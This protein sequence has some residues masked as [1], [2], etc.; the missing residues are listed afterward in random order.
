MTL[1]QLKIGFIP[2]TDAA[3]LVM[4]KE[5]GFFEEEGLSVDLV[6]AR[7]WAQTRDYLAT[8]ELDAAHMLAPMVPASWLPG[9]TG[10]IPFV[11]GLSLNLNGNAITV[12]SALY[13]EMVEADPEALTERPLSSRALKSVLAKRLETTGEPVTFGTVFPFSSHNYAL[14][15]WLADEYIDPDRDV[16][17]VVAPPQ[18]MVEQ[19]EKGLI[20][21]FCVG[22]PWNSLAEARGAGRVILRSREIWQDMPEKVLGVRE[23]W[24]KEHP[25]THLKL[26]KAVLRACQWLDTPKHRDEAAYHLAGP[27]YL[28][29]NPGVLSVALSSKSVKTNYRSLMQ[30][31]DSIIFHHNAANFPWQSHACWFL[32]QMI[33]WGQVTEDLDINQIAE[34]CYLPDLYRQAAHDLG[35]LA[36]ADASKVEGGQDR[37]WILPAEGGLIP[38]S[39]NRFF[40]QSAFDP[41]RIGSYINSFI[42]HNIRIDTSKI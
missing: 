15:Y 1:S 35:I 28:G 2:L 19:M 18:V 6:K 7:S 26:V 39:P 31:P 10:R 17:I 38:M 14:R 23:A 29:V 34:N 22:E 8:G 36:P 9:D 30:L 3:P 16:R 41:A 40:D 21:A 25:E 20:D 12:S 32:C 4:A 11:T 24:A 13:Q 37:S 42:R 27:A 5:K 33:R